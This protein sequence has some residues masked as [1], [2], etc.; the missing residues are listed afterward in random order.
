VPHSIRD[1]RIS[2]NR[3]RHSFRLFEG[4]PYFFCAPCTTTPFKLGWGFSSSIRTEV[5]NSAGIS[6]SPR[7]AAVSEKQK[8]I[9]D[10]WH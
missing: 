3:P 7:F 4:A 5:P 1:Y 6:Y 2:S 9:I 10:F 8:F